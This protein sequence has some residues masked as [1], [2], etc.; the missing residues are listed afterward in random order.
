MTAQEALDHFR[1][2]GITLTCTDGT[3]RAKPRHLVTPAVSELIQIHKP[4]LLTLLAAE[5][6]PSPC[7]ESGALSPAVERQA[8]QQGESPVPGAT[9]THAPAPLSL[10]LHSPTCPGL[11]FRMQS[12]VGWYCPQCSR[13]F[14]VPPVPVQTLPARPGPG[15]DR[16][17]GEPQ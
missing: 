5:S 1:A 6:S 3:L 7:S 4:A 16:R 15:G 13:G 11:G 8:Q 9:D 2:Q 14:G 10:M 17:Q 12:G